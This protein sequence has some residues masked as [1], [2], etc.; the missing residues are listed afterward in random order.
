MKGYEDNTFK[1]D[2]LST[3]E[4]VCAVLNAYIKGDNRNESKINEAVNTLKE[5]R[6]VLII[7][8]R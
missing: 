4:E 2:K 5:G 8:H 6:A 3:R 1:P 7:A